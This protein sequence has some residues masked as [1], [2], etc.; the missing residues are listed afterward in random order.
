MS[1]S[2]IVIVERGPDDFIAKYVHWDAYLSG[3][4]NSLAM[5]FD[6]HARAVAFVDHDAPQLQGDTWESARDMVNVDGVDYLYLWRG[7]EWWY[8]VEAGRTR[9]RSGWTAVLD[10]LAQAEGK[11]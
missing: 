11:E 10:A 2:A 3:L 8:C 7:A 6:T 1:T 5:N 4:G 9:P